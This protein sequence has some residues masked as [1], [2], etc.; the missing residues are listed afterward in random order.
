MHWDAN[1]R[2]RDHLRTT[3]TAA[4]RYAAAKQAA[5]AS[6]AARLL[7]YSDAKGP[8]LVELLRDAGVK[9]MATR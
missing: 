4:A 3:P 7:A 9:T 5:L 1:L 8:V 2:L 6:D